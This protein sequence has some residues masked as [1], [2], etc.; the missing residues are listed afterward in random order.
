MYQGFR[1]HYP[2]RCLLVG[3]NEC[4][5]KFLQMWH[6]RRLPFHNKDN[7]RSHSNR[8]LY[9]FQGSGEQQNIAKSRLIN[10]STFKMHVLNSCRLKWNMSLHVNCF[11]QL[12]SW[13]GIEKSAWDKKLRFS[14]MVGSTR[15]ND[16]SLTIIFK[17]LIIA[18]GRI[19]TIRCNRRWATGSRI[20]QGLHSCCI[21]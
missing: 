19:P 8:W 14:C 17:R 6:S 15:N 7:C 16:D 10:Y 18:G 9:S 1:S 2:R 3:M 11:I 13:I 5:R 20:N 12:T 4:Q 21:L